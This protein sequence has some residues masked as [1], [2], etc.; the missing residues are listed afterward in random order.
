MIALLRY[1]GSCIAVVLAG[2][3]FADFGTDQL[4]PHVSVAVGGQYDTNVFFVPDDEIASASTVAEAVAGYRWQGELTGLDVAVDGRYQQ[5][6]EQSLPAASA[7]R[8]SATL[9]REHEFGSTRASVSFRDTSALINALDNNG[10]FVGDERQK[11]ASSSVRRIFEINETNA[12]VTT[13]AGSRV[14]YVDTPPGVRQDDYDFATAASQWEWQYG[15]RVTLG[16]GVVGSWYKSNGEVFTNEVTTIGPALTLQYEL[17]E[18]TAGS[19]EFS[20][21]RSDG[22]AVYFGFLEQHDTGGNYYGRAGISREFDRANVSLD[23][24][25]SVQP[26]SN[27]R[28][29]IRDEVTASFVREMSDRVTLRGAATALESAPDNEGSIGAPGDRR[30]AFAGDVRMDVQFGEHVSVSAGYRYLW[31]NAD[32]PDTEAQAH[33]LSVTLHWSLGGSTA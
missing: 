27:G 28:Q 2:T 26:G 20:Y 21:R 13:L 30:T 4:V 31:Q 11:T 19:F 3:A 7:F 8:V 17:G 6:A 16:A 22:E 1:L 33:T 12:I 25:R 14:T 9:D 10:K 15:E 5:Y 32:G 24:S 18:S 29:E 23:A